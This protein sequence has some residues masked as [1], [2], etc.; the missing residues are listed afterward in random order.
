MAR[1]QDPQVKEAIAAALAAVC[2]NGD[3]T[4]PHE[5]SVLSNA[6]DTALF[7]AFD[8]ARPPGRFESW[9]RKSL[10]KI[11]ACFRVVR[12]ETT[13]PKHT[14]AIELSAVAIFETHWRRMHTQ[15]D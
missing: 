7:A 3:V 4:A 9:A 12:L 8:A 6:W 14:D 11:A 2:R 1:P 15:E 5:G 13:S 10:P